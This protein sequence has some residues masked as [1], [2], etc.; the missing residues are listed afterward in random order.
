M[1]GGDRVLYR[2]THALG[3]HAFVTDMKAASVWLETG[4]VY[5]V[6]CVVERSGVQYAYLREV[7]VVP[8]LAFPCALFERLHGDRPGM[9][10]GQHVDG[11]Q[12]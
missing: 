8:P 10:L 12:T 7:Q 2:G 5:N 3:W 4:S 1:K 11:R 9:L 6:R